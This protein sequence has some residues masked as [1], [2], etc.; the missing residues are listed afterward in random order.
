MLKNDLFYP[1]VEAGG[2]GEALTTEDVIDRLAEIRREG[3][4]RL[5]ANRLQKLARLEAA[6]E[7]FDP[8]VPMD[9]TGLDL[10]GVQ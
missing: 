8:S 6:L 3:D 2:T 5:V 4:Q 7:A 9:Q 1:Y 10:R